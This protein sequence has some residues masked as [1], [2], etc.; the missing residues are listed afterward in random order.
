MP[1]TD[2]STNADAGVRRV[3]GEPGIWVLIFGDLLV[4]GLFFVTFA[5]YHAQD[6]T[7]FANSRATLNQ[8]CGLINTVLLLTSSWLVALAMVSLRAN[9][10]QFARFYVAMAML[11]G[12]GFV[13]DKVFEYHE[14]WIAGIGPT[15]NDFFM[16]YFCFT[17]IHLL[18]VIIG[19]GAL[20]YVYLRSV[21][22]AKAAEHIALVEG[23][24]IFWHL[25]DIL[26]LVL[27]ALFY[28][29]G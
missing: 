22:G 6:P 16:L 27:F 13:G 19:L 8:S 17:G 2:Q 23:C 26:W 14:K 11:C 12:L 5:I 15:T 3:P 9:G 28:L 25:V 10:A 18:H 20:S 29:H 1:L 21:G 24:T 4:F 7:Q